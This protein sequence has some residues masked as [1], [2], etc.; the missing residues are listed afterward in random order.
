MC[1]RSQ[2]QYWHGCELGGVGS[3]ADS[4]SGRGAAG[5]AGH[6]RRSSAAAKPQTRRRR[7]RRRRRRWSCAEVA[8]SRSF[9]AC[10]CF[11]LPLVCNCSHHLLVSC[12]KAS[13]FIMMIIIVVIGNTIVGVILK[14]RTLEISRPP[15][16]A[17][18]AGYNEAATPRLPAACLAADMPNPVRRLLAESADPPPPPSLQAC[19]YELRVNGDQKNQKFLAERHLFVT[20]QIGTSY[21]A[22]AVLLCQGARPVPD[23][24]HWHALR[25]WALLSGAPASPSAPLESGSSCRFGD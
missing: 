18:A 5:T 25:M 2:T 20:G 24:A 22:G 8:R 17:S 6:R 9:A 23:R 3:P 10:Q 4:D 11:K 21:P 12:V 19:R 7:Q 15:T 14:I 1:L 16:P 13:Y